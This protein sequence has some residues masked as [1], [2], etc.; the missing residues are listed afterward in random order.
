MIE[1]L[2]D[3]LLLVSPIEMMVPVSSDRMPGSAPRSEC[4]HYP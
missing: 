4:E 3:T 1:R 2:I